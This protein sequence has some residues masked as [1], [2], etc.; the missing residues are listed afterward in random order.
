[1]SIAPV[2]GFPPA[3]SEPAKEASV[4]SRNTPARPTKTA[5]PERSSESVSGTP[6]EESFVLRNVPSANELSQDTVELHQDPE[7]K[8]QVI[9][10]YLDHSKNLVLQVPSN[11]ELSV[12]RGIA[13]EVQ[14]ATTLRASERAAAAAGEGEDNHGHQL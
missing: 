10:E 12:E 4:R 2:Q 7:I 6:G 3:R 8:G 13:Q 5:V 9:V 14:Q 11:Q 1:M